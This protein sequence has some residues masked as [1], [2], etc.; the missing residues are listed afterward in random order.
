MSNSQHLLGEQQANIK[1]LLV[2]G[3]ALHSSLSC[4]NHSSHTLGAVFICEEKQTSADLDGWSGSTVTDVPQ[5]KHVH[6][7]PKKRRRHK[8][9]ATTGLNSKCIENIVFYFQSTVKDGRGTFGA[10]L[11]QISALWEKGLVKHGSW[12]LSG[13]VKCFVINLGF[14][15][16]APGSSVCV[17]MFL[18]FFFR[19]NL[20][21]CKNG[22]K[23][24]WHA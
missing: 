9:R 19:S 12:K 7:A 16:A 15:T 4:A 14:H 5:C 17:C 2:S 6:L 3:V 22:L 24:V 10:S 1:Q 11:V 23:L 13:L 20:R 18:V 21:Q 8:T